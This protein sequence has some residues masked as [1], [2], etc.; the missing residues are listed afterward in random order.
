MVGAGWHG[1]E[2][3]TAREDR[4]ESPVDG[5]QEEGSKKLHFDWKGWDLGSDPSDGMGS[6]LEKRGW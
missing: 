5:F 2:S 1:G 4:L 6:G 3:D